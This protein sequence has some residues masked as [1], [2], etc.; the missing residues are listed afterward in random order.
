M[1]FSGSTP[2]VRWSD[3]QKMLGEQ[4]SFYGSLENKHVHEIS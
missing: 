4:E 1:F 3:P 2:D